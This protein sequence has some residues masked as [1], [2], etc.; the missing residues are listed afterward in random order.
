MTYR[1]ASVSTASRG[2]ERQAGQ[3]AELAEARLGEVDAAAGEGGGERGAGRVDHEAR[4]LGRRDGGDVAVALVGHAGGAA[5]A[6]DDVVEIERGERVEAGLPFGRRDRR[7]FGNEAVFETGLA[8]ID[9]VAD[10]GQIIDADRMGGERAGGEQFVEQRTG[11]TAAEIDR[12]RVPAERADHPGDVDATAAGIVALAGRADL[13]GGADTVGLAGPVDGRVECQ[14]HD[15]LHVIPESS[16]AMSSQPTP[17]ARQNPRESP[18]GG[19]GSGRCAPG[20]SLTGRSSSG[21]SSNGFEGGRK[22]IEQSKGCSRSGQGP[23]VGTACEVGM[24]ASRS[25]ALIAADCLR[26]KD[27]EAAFLDHIMGG[28]GAVMVPAEDDAA[29]GCAMRYKLILEI[30]EGCFYA[31]HRRRAWAGIRAGSPPHSR[32]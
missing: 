25:S 14:G 16:G 13:V 9:G 18:P 20:D 5:A 21:N 2:F 24:T 6:G 17:R 3:G 4:A 27:L 12:E 22:V 15:R 10:P 23:S 11:G 26:A 30:A 28:S 31:R 1:R 29:V 19:F 32:V 7:A 8:L